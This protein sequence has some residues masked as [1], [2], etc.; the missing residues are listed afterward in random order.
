MLRAVVFDVDF[1]LA[2]PGPD[3][4]PDGLPRARAPL[5]ARPRPG[6]V[7]G[8]AGGGVRGG[9]AASGARPRRGDLGA[10]HRADHRGDGRAGA[11]RTRAAVEMERR[12]AHS[13]HFELYDDALP[14]LDDMRRARAEDRAALELV[15]EPR[16]VRRPPRARRPTRCSPRA[17]TGRRSR[18]SRSSSRCSSCSRST[19]AEAVMVGDTLHDDIEGALA[20]GMQAVLL[21]REGRHPGVDGPARRPA[22]PR[23]RRSG[24]N[25]SGSER[26]RGRTS[27]RPSSTTPPSATA[28]AGGARGSARRPG[29]AQIGGCVYEL[30]DG[31]RTYPYH[32]H[33]AMEEW[34]SCSRAR[35]RCAGPTASA[36]SGPGDVVCFPTGPE[37]AHQVT[38]PGSVLIL[39]ASRGARGDRVPG[40]RQGRRLAAGRDLPDADAVDY[41]E[42]E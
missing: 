9:E 13:A 18:T 10:L 25:R 16:G 6:A 12:W 11:T 21:D 31:E 28:T 39:S 17:R 15:A 14:A 19:P 35:R 2:R 40:Q 33:H 1:T 22:R 23:R 36:C 29:R 7:R 8:G 42:G 37:G 5:R 41:W 32:F 38:G 27:S 30:A 3:L 20:V 4:G 34:L 24:S 26:G